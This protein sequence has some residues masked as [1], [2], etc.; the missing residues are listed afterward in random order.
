M[1]A[2]YTP[3]YCLILYF[4]IIKHHK[5]IHTIK[6]FKNNFKQ[7]YQIVKK[8][9]KKYLQY[10]QIFYFMLMITDDYI[11]FFNSKEATITKYFIDSSEVIDRKLIMGCTNIINIIIWKIINKL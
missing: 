7:F 6:Q 1:S 9:E 10:F 3:N 4:N 11:Y 2:I 8:H 5:E